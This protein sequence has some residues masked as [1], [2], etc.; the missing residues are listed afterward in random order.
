MTTCEF[1]FSKTL[2]RYFQD[3]LERNAPLDPPGGWTDLSLMTLAG[4]I[5]ARFCMDGAKM[6]TAVAVGNVPKEQQ[7][8][9]LTDHRAAVNGAMQS[10]SDLVAMMYSGRFEAKFNDRVNGIVQSAGGK[11]KLL[12]EQESY[13]DP[14]K[15]GFNS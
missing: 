1:E 3:A 13:R 15:E 10:C 12:L 9:L 11:I 2:A 7:E 8:A 4:C 6:W 14:A 5:Q